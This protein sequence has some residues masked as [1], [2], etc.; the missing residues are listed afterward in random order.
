MRE[1]R[2]RNQCKSCGCSSIREHGRRKRNC[3]CTCCGGSLCD[4]GCKRSRC[5][6]SGDPS[7]CDHGLLRSKCDTC[8]LFDV[9]LCRKRRS[10]HP[11]PSSPTQQ[12]QGLCCSG[13]HITRM[14]DADN[15]LVAWPSEKPMQRAVIWRRYRAAQAASA[16]S[17]QAPRHRRI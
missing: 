7:I 14:S 17:Y 3:T 15:G 2:V 6:L 10:R 13:P 16:P 1:N 9:L 4:N 5:N 8:A 11:R 12:L